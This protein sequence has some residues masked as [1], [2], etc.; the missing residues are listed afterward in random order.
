VVSEQTLRLASSCRLVSS[1]L[2][3][4]VQALHFGWHL[5]QLKRQRGE[6]AERMS[7]YLC[8]ADTMESLPFPER[9]GAECCTWT[10]SVDV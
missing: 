7:V 9:S 8:D 3:R 10:T 2:L 6:G 1:S 4:S 5:F